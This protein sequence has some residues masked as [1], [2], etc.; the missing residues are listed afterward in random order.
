MVKA[1]ILAAG[2]STRTY[3]L[4]ISKPKPLLKVA[5][6]TILQHNLE[7]LLGLVEEAI[8]V[9]GYKKEMIISKYKNRFK[10]IQLRYVE[11]KKQLGTGNALL[12]TKKCLKKNDD[13]IVIMGDNI[14]DKKSIKRVLKKKYSVLSK[15]IDDP[16]NFGVFIVK[17]HK[18]VDVIEKPKFFISKYA[19]CA[20]YHLDYGIFEVLEKLDKT[21]RNEF[22]LTDGIKKFAQDKE[23]FIVK[24]KFWIPIGYP[25]ELLYADK[26]LR[27]KSIIGKNSKITGSVINSTIGDNCIIKG[28]VKNSIVGDDS[29]IEKHSVI[30]N[31]VIGDNVK[32]SG[33]IMA[34]KIA[35][36][37]VKNMFVD[38]KNI[39]AIIGNKV[40]AD[41]V[42]IKAGSKIWPNLKIK[43]KIQGDRSE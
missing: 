20:L 35:K 31:S 3:P 39:G 38:V 1:I 26:F 15:K 22:E 8:I 25:W 40:T 9:V 2:K 14:Y 17:N 5:N 13:F 36:S 27:S 33:I 43:G 10:G 32:F 42:I 19:N 28:K 41:N 21:D 7:Q 30:E 34:E 6:K 11:Q 4:T 16:S 24:T 12:V 23:V 37:K 18:V 29:I